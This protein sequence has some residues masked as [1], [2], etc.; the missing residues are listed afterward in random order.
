MTINQKY[1]MKV[2]L[3]GGHYLVQLRSHNKSQKY[4]LYEGNSSPVCWLNS[5]QVKF[6][7]PFFKEDKKGRI[8]LNL[9]LVRQAHG[10]SL[11]KIYYKKLISNKAATAQCGI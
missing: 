7:K 10:K 11:L 3:E 2:L 5:S 6:L 8:T 9:N 4:K 1:L